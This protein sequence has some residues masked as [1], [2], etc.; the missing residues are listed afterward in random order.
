MRCLNVESLIKQLQT[1]DPKA[2][3]VVPGQ[4]HSYRTFGACNSTTAIMGS[5]GRTSLSEDYGF[6]LESYETRVSVAVLE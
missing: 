2:Y 3:V 4:D 5:E 6:D 1:M